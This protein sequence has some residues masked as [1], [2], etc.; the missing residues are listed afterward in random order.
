MFDLKLNSYMCMVATVLDSA[1]L[2]DLEN[3]FLC[4][5]VARWV[6]AVELSKP[7]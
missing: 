3:L 2:E 4:V 7:R 1:D 5:Y 6:G